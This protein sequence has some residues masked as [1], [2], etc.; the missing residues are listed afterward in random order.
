MLPWLLVLYA[1]SVSDLGR[2]FIP[3]A[4]LAEI[5]IRSA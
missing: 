4:G 1:L 2:W 5:L 3:G